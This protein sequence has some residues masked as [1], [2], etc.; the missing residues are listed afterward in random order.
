[1]KRVCA[2]F[3][4]KLEFYSREMVKHKAELNKRSQRK[5][6]GIREL[7]LELHGLDVLIAL[8]NV[9]LTV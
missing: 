6:G 1:M 4:W 5:W 3:A 8:G 2:S 7:H 9:L